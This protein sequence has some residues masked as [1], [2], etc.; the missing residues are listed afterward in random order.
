MSDDEPELNKQAGSAYTKL[1]DEQLEIEQNRRA[2]IE[3]RGLSVLTTSGTLV[4]LLFAFSALV[5][6]S[7]TF[8]LGT[9]AR[10]MIV[11]SLLFFL[12]AGV[13]GIATNWPLP[14]EPIDQRDLSR[15]LQPNLW[16]AS[17]SPAARRVAEAKI[18]VLGDV[19]QAN[20]ARGLFLLVAMIMQVAAVFSL[21]SGIVIILME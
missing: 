4:T 6:Q 11:G 14:W 1:I 5:T 17:L 3:Q 7:K 13:S 2:S 18:D 19:R 21:A 15:L 20:N 10:V 12:L 16:T 8:R 9:P